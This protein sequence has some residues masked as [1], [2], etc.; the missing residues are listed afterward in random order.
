MEAWCGAAA[1]VGC[2][3]WVTDELVSGHDR[4]RH[5]T[6]HA[7]ALTARQEPGPPG[8]RWRLQYSDASDFVTTL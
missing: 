2:G 5:P 7:R 3:L 6:S 4:T 1:G 8:L